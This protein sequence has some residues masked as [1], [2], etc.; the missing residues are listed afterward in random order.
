MA[1]ADRLAGGSRRGDSDRSLHLVRANVACETTANLLGGVEFS[2][3]EG[4]GP[5]DEY[6]RTLVIWHLRFEQPE[7]PLCAVHG[8]PRD[9]TP[10]GLTERLR[11]SNHPCSN[12]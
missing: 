4:A 3:G 2:P 10:V 5:G 6:P 7:S 11:R 12:S 1:D 9:K 8:P